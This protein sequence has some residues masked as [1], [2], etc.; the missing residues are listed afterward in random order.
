MYHSEILGDKCNINSFLRSACTPIGWD[1]EIL[2]RDGTTVTSA[3]YDWMQLVSFVPRSYMLTD[4][5][6]S[7]FLRQRINVRWS[8]STASKPRSL[9][10]V[11]WNFKT[12]CGSTK[13]NIMQQSYHICNEQIKIARD[14]AKLGLSGKAVYVFTQAH[15]YLDNLVGELRKRGFNLP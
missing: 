5:N 7:S 6:S 10:T 12:L 4:E 13:Q 9:V 11:R 14:I 8:G 2:T 15:S 3:K 1:C